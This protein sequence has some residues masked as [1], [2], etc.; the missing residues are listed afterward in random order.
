MI[1]K[2]KGRVQYKSIGSK[3]INLKLIPVRK[4]KIVL[5][6]ILIDNKKG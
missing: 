6:D 1:G 2:V 4:G 3:V 5:P